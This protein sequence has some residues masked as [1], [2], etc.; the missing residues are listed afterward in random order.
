MNLINIC[1]EGYFLKG[2]KFYM[3]IP[4]RYLQILIDTYYYY[5]HQMKSLSWYNGI[6]ASKSTMTSEQKKIVNKTSKKKFWFK[7]TLSFEIIFCF[8]KYFLM[9]KIIVVF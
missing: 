8:E 3:T 6:S 4:S 5:V 7:G 9:T 1:I 2:Y